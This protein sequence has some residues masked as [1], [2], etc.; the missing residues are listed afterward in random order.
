MFPNALPSEKAAV[1]GTIDPDAY[2]AADDTPYVSD[3]VDMADFNQLLAVLLAGTV[4][5]SVTINAKLVQATSAA[6]AGA[7]DVTGK[8]ITA[9]TTADS[10][11]QVLINCRADDLDAA[12]GFRYVALS[13]TISDSASPDAAAADFGAVL[14]GFD[15]RY[16]PADDYDLASV[17]EIVN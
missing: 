11:K 12:G 9:L 1:V 15:P 17:D 6:G 8:A 7:K 3:Y 4:A 2:A 5:A 10:D 14:L 13:V 16:G